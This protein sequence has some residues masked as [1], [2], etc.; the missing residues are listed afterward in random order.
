MQIH[1]YV[2]AAD[3]MEDNCPEICDLF[4]T[5]EAQN[6]LLGSPWKEESVPSENDNDE[7]DIQDLFDGINPEEENNDDD[8]SSESEDESLN[9]QQAKKISDEE[10]KNLR[11]KEL[12]K[13]LRNIPWEEAAKI[14]K[15]RRNLKNRGYALNCRLRK[16]REH[17]DLMNENTLLKKQLEDGKWK[18]LKVWNEKESYKKKYVQTQ[19]AFAAYK[20][21]LEG[22]LLIPCR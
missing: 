19:R 20:Q 3:N 21:E 22:S 13:R 9:P 5:N 12:N 8:T 14:R 15:R 17:E 18:L 7:R 11:L 4:F 16:Q 6:I 2:N 10:I 1:W